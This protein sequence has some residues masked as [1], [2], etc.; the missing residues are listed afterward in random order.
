MEK[1]ADFVF[2]FP[3]D[4]TTVDSIQSLRNIRLGLARQMAGSIEKTV[5]EMIRRGLLHRNERSQHI[6]TLKSHLAEKIANLQKRGDDADSIYS[7]ELELY[8][9][10]MADPNDEDL[11]QEE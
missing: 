3:V 9:G 11:N 4:E 8:L 5:D 6:Q 1:R 7:D 2:N 10:L